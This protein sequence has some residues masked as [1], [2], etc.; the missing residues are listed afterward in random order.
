MTSRR[1]CT[2]TRILNKEYAKGNGLEETHDEGL[3]PRRLRSPTA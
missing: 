3:P 1:S 2:R